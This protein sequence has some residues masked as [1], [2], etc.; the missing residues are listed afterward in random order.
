M[1]VGP[2]PDPA[3]FGAA[4]AAAAKLLRVVFPGDIPICH[5][6]LVWCG[7]PFLSDRMGYHPTPDGKIHHVLVQHGPFRR[8]RNWWRRRK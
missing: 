1:P 2:L 4:G 5:T 8:A 3:V 7:I 6:R